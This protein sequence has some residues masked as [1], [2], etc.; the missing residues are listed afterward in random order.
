MSARAARR[1]RWSSLRW[2]LAALAGYC[3][4]TRAARDL[5]QRHGIC[6]SVRAETAARLLHGERQP[7]YWYD[8][9]YPQQKFDKPG[10]SPFMDMQ[11]VPKYADEEAAAA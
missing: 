8:P 10:K 2:L 6:G 11:L 5:T 7:L 1:R 9:M 4:R 3:R